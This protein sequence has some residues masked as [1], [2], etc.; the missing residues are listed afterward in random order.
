MPFEP[1]L[2]TNRVSRT[3]AG[4]WVL[5]PKFDGWRAIV[6][7][8][9]DVRVWTRTGHELTERLPELAPLVDYCGGVSVV[10][11]GELVAGQGRAADFYG[12]LPRV[13][14]RRRQEPLT[15]VA[16]DVLAFDGPVIDQPYC[17]RRALLQRLELRG[18]A[19]CTRPA[20]ARHG[21]RFAER[22]RRTRRRG[23]RRETNR[24]ALPSR[25]TER[26]LAQSENGGLARH[27]RIAPPPFV[28]GCRVGGVARENVRADLLAARPPYDAERSR[29]DRLSAKA[30]EATRG[31]YGRVEPRSPAC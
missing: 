8:D 17:R 21:R 24:L 3:L 30:E 11:D 26:R 9:Q 27:A 16:F 25:P 2:A 10:L 29:L 22:L 28:V 5:E 14:A 23:H 18:P 20:T 4:K 19:W 6:A 31:G 7:V 1:M 12:L 15:F 13:A